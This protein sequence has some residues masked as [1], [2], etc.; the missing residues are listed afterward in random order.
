MS[1]Q[2]H[3]D[4]VVTRHTGLVQYL[5]DHDLVDKYTRVIPHATP[6]EVRN[7]RVCG[8]LPHSLSCLCD[9]FTEV[10]LLNLPPELRGVEL[11]YGQLKQYA[12]APVTYQ[13]R[14]VD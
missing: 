1:P 11:S 7:K 2:R 9:T 13:V 6:N 14:R 10:P 8:V 4:L 5:L 12:G 3:I